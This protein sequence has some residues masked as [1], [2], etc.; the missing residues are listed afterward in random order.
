MKNLKNLGKTLNKVEQKEIF[1]G[2]LTHF[3]GEGME[4]IENMCL[5][6]PNPNWNLGPFNTTD[7]DTGLPA[8][9]NQNG[10]PFVTGVCRNGECFYS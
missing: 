1:G 7:P 9:P 6:M 4:C 5:N 2:M 3:P 10:S 8:G